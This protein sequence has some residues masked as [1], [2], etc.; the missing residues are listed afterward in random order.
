MHRITTV[1]DIMDEEEMDLYRSGQVTGD[2]VLRAAPTT[3]S[4][5]MSTVFA[6]EL[7]GPVPLLSSISHSHLPWA[8]HLTLEWLLQAPWVALLVLLLSV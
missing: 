5:R 4:Q 6:A 8:L 3:T 1:E 2:A 7:L